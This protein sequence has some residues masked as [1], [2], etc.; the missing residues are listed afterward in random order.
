MNEVS[1][2]NDDP[3]S[4]VD[5]REIINNDDAD[6]NS[7]SEIG[8]TG[9]SSDEDL[10]DNDNFYVGR[11]KVTMWRKTSYSTSSKTKKKNIV[12]IFP[13]PKGN[14]R[15]VN[16][17]MKAFSCI[18]DDNIIDHIIRCTNL[19]IERKQIGTN[20]TRDRRFREVSRSEI[21]ALLG[22]LY[23]IGTKKG[24]HTNVLELWSSDGTGIQILRA[25]MSYDRFL[26]I[27]RS[28]RFDD[29]STR[30]ERI[31]TDKLAAIR[32]VLDSFTEN[33][34][35]CYNPGEFIAID[36]KLEPFRGRCNFIQYIPHKP[37]KY[38]I[39]IFALCDAKTFFTSNIEVYCGKQPDGPFHA[40]NKPLDIVER[41]VLP[42]ADSNRNLTTV[43]WY[44]SYP[45]G[46]SLL[47][48]GI[49]IV[50]TLRKDK[51][52]YLAIRKILHSFLMI[53]KGRNQLYCCPLCTIKE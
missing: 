35:T 16:G 52:A 1:D 11:D 15:V 14:A 53:R 31:R 6:H 25:Y 7:D 27:L 5:E 36:E 42:F 8:Y 3:P 33:C 12:K 47:K 40:S 26:Q 21:L 10:E 51:R 2:D 44:T 23:L 38:G 34:K 4:D 17:E 28:I 18:M 39:K 30:S 48:K 41:L 19:F 49:T 13:G 29:K 20:F 46:L 22:L 45:L 24:S 37:A 50:G 43:N 32:T 9:S